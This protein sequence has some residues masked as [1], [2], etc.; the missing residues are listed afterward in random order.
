MFASHYI[1]MVLVMLAGMFLLG[2]ALLLAAAGLGAS[3][4][5][6]RRTRPAWFSEAWASR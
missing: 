5:S 3:P 6:F 4:M 1:G 2:G